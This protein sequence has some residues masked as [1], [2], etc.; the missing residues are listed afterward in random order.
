MAKWQDDEYVE[1]QARERFCMVRPGEVPLLVLDDPDGAARDAGSGRPAGARRAPDP[2]YD[3]LW[4]S[5][6]AANA[7]PG[8]VSAPTSARGWAP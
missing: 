8:P 2:W 4:S 5:V 6:Q 1:I 7:E 3:T